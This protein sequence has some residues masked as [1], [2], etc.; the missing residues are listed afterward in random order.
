MG[1]VTPKVEPFEPAKSK[2]IRSNSGKCFEIFIRASKTHY[3]FQSIQNQ[4]RRR[5]RKIKIDLNLNQD[6]EV[7]KRKRTKKTKKKRKRR[8]TKEKIQNYINDVILQ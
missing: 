2:K 1:A 7:R 4:E 6:P 5:K 8:K 3:K